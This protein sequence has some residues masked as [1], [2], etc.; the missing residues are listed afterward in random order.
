MKS[1]RR[2]SASSRK[3]PDG[4]LFTL[5]LLDV[6]PYTREQVRLS[7]AADGRWDVQL[8]LA[9]VAD[10]LMVSESSPPAADRGHPARTGATPSAVLLPLQS[11]AGG[12]RALRA[13]LLAYGSATLLQSLGPDA[14]DDVL[15]DPWT[16][17][18]LRFRL[19]RL[20]Q[21]SEFSCGGRTLTWGR[22]WLADG[23]QAERASISPVQHDLL[24][25]LGH[26]GDDPV[27]REA[28]EGVVPDH[29]PGSRA[30]DMHISRL[31]AKLDLVATAWTEPPRI[32]C[33][34]GIG[35]RIE[36][37]KP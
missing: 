9:G 10:G 4:R 25:I 2:S 11:A 23:G 30:L 1:S 31:R 15:V 26:A 8:A 12:A 13:P 33:Y 37:G 18:E 27:P 6:D 32:V 35:Y 20:V 17:D 34:R 5:L 36:C 28:L 21:L 22:Y 14:C 19:D 7:L 3:S 24:E 16:S 29:A